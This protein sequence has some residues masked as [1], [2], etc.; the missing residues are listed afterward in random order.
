MQQ[1]QQP[2]LRACCR[3]RRPAPAAGADG[4]AA[5]AVLR[6]QRERHAR[7]HGMLRSAAHACVQQWCHVLYTCCRTWRPSTSCCWRSKLP[8]SSCWTTVSAAAGLQHQ[9]AARA[10]H[11]AVFACRPAPDVPLHSQSF[12]T[13]L[14]A[15]LP[16][17]SAARASNAAEL[18]AAAE[19]LAAKDAQESDLRAMLVGRVETLPCSRVACMRMRRL[20][21]GCVL[22]ACTRMLNKLAP[23]RP[24][25]TLPRPSLPQR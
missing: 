7:V 19:Q 9:Q 12:H 23:C 4:G 13:H 10:G 15:C 21:R 3:S 16:A 14:P 8:R 1:Q 17:A 5:G 22:P 24:C 2:C 25:R 18:R 11:A 6:G 20:R